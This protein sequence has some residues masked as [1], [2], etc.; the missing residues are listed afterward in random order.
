MREKKLSKLLEWSGSL[1]GIS[2]AIL[3]ALNIP[4]SAWAYLF[5]LLSSILLL[6]WSLREQAHGLAFQNFVFI[7]INLLGIYRWLIVP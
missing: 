1:T 6:L 2:A 7:A 5:Y 3:L 4:I